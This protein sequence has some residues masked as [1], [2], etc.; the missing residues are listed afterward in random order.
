M[1]TILDEIMTALRQPDIMILGVYGS[2]SNA[3]KDEVVKRI[4]RRV[5]RDGVFDVIVMAT[6]MEKNMGSSRRSKSPDVRR[7]QEELGNKLGLQLQ[8][9]TT[10]KERASCLF[11]G[12]KMKAKILIILDDVRGGINLAEI[13]IPF[14]N[15]HN[16]CK[17]LLVAKNQEVLSN[18]MNAP[19]KIIS[20]SRS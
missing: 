16:G 8:D 19:Q 3:R 12:I 1:S 20:V 14:G 11:D 7:I 5:E 2:T 18:Q 17:I 4:T 13:G 10:L 9:K 15:D 6:V